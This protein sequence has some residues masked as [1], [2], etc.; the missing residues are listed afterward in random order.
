M[1]MKKEG[2]DTMKYIATLFW[3]FCLGQV[4]NY[5]G[6]SL[7]SGTYS[8]FTA[9]LIGLL[10]AVIVLLLTSAIPKPPETQH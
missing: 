10:S 3:G 2:V 9:T 6:S 1:V 8:F 7:T 5:I 4:V